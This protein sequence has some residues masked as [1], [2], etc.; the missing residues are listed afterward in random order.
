[1]V[2]PLL[3]RYDRIVSLRE[4]VLSLK[5]G[6]PSSTSIEKALKTLEEEYDSKLEELNHRERK[7]VQLWL[8]E[9]RAL[10]TDPPLLQW[11]RRE[12]EPLIVRPL[13]FWPPGNSFSCWF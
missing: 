8:D 9:R 10:S 12:Y 11:D 1:M 5:P 7:R 3:D 2:D 4:D 6:D 13:D